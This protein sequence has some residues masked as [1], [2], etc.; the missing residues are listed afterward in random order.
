MT[1]EVTMIEILVT[2]HPSL[3]S[4]DQ[5]PSI[6]FELPRIEVLVDPFTPQIPVSAGPCPHLVVAEELEQNPLG[7]VVE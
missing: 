1:G 3:S 7:P 5:V 6:G 2:D 4:K